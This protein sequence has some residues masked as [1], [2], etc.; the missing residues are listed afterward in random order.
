MQ[1]QRGAGTGIMGSPASDEVV[2][3]IL[4]RDFE[5]SAGTTGNPDIPWSWV[6]KD[7]DGPP[8]KRCGAEKTL[9]EAKHQVDLWW[10]ERN[11]DGA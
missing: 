3:V 7:Y 10:E 1:A 8:D 2:T 11:D 9:D 6:H 4:Y 5:I